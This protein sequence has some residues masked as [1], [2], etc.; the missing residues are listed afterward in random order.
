MLQSMGSQRIGRDLATEEQ[1]QW[2]IT[3][4]MPQSFIDLVVE[5][6]T[7]LFLMYTY[8]Y[9]NVTNSQ[10]SR[11]LNKHTVLPTSCPLHL[12]VL[13]VQR[14]QRPVRSQRLL[15]SPVL[16][17]GLQVVMCEGTSNGMTAWQ[18]KKNCIPPTRFTYKGTK[19]ILKSKQICWPRMAKQWR[20]D[21]KLKQKRE[22][23]LLLILSNLSST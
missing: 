9:F 14:R 7:V 15:S 3:Q 23:W 17:F 5:L 4:V 10:A 11:E 13:P 2:T 6:F 8:L 18:G 12:Q 19:N 20:W 22:T 21:W 1:Q 16:C